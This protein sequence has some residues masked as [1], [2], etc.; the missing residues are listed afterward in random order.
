MA[1]LDLFDGRDKKKRLS[2]VRNLLALAASDGNLDQNEFKLIVGLAATTGVSESDFRRAI[3]RPDSIPFIVPNSFRERL[4]QLHDMVLVMV[5]DGRITNKELTI[6][7]F[8]A[9]K[10][11]F[12]HEI[13][14]SIIDNVIEFIEKG[15][16]QENILAELEKQFA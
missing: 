16:A 6:C 2:H 4:E 11:G 13:I 10:L 3:S 1:L 8:T 7:K 15:M 14:D 9:V 12:R 5:I